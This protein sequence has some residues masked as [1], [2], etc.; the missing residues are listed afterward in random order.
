M[1]KP[2]LLILFL[3]LA[4]LVVY[5]SAKA[6]PSGQV[7]RLR[8]LKVTENGVQPRTLQGEPEVIGF[9]CTSTLTSEE[10]TCYAL[11][12]DRVF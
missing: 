2:A 1:K 3:I 4:L 10:L 5:T 9:S 8:I 11:L 12:R 7:V 6:R